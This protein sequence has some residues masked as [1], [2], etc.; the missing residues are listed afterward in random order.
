MNMC[1]ALFRARVD[2]LLSVLFVVLGGLL[3]SPT[4]GATVPDVN[5]DSAK[6]SGKEKPG[7][8]IV[9]CV[10]FNVRYQTSGDK[11]PRNWQQRLPVVLKAVVQMDP[12]VMGVQEALDGQLD[13]LQKGLSDYAVFGVGR[14]DGKSRGEHVSIFFRKSRFSRDQNESGH[15]WLSDTPAK[16]AS[17]SWGNGIT[18][19]CTWLRLIDKNT[20]RGFYVFNTHWDHRHQGSREQAAQLIARKIDQ[21]KHGADPVVLMGDFNA[22]ETNQAI[23]YLLGE[24]IKLEGS[25]NEEQWAAPMLDVFQKLHPNETNRRTFNQWVGKKE[26]MAKI[27]HIFVSAGAQVMEAGIEYYH[28]GEVYPSDHYPVRAKLLFP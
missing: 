1:Y 13:N 15:F 17:K 21:R 5:A 10:S 28:E 9:E 22:V 24:K 4:A 18:R 25:E 26:G 8:L 2:S 12:D 14:D 6:G 11:G 20:G 19:M 23:Q 7:S 27:D 16:V 3:L